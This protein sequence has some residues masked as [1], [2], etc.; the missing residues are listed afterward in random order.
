LLTLHHPNDTPNERAIFHRL[1]ETAGSV[2]LA[3]D[4]A[5]FYSAVRQAVIK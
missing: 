2:R 5:T 4:S 3:G 1:V